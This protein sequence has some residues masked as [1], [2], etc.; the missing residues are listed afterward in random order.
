MSL[1]ALFV[2]NLNSNGEGFEANSDILVNVT[3]VDSAETTF[4]ENVIG[5][6]TLGD[7]LKL[8][9][10]EGNNVSVEESILSGVLEVAR[11]GRRITQI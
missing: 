3:L 2:E 4:T 1:K 10:C 9:Q 6:K 8:V 7:S 5:A 11:G